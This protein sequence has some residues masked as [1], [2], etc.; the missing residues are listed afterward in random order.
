MIS[1]IIQARMGSTRLPGKVLKPLGGKPMLQVQIER[2]R[3]AHRLD[4]VVVATSSLPGDDAIA[5]FCTGFEVPCF[6]GSETDVLSRYHGC[7][8]ERGADVIVRLT[9]DCP[10]TD[11]DV[12]DAVVELRE[13]EDA[14]YACNTVPPD[15]GRWPDGSDVEVFT[16]AAL[17]RAHTEARE[18][19]EREHVTFYLWE[20]A[21]DRGFKTT[22]LGRDFDLSHLRFTV[23]Y[24]EDFEVV[25]FVFEELR[26]KRL[27]GHVDE[28]ATLIEANPDIKCKNEKYFFGIGWGKK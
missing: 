14:D 12:I 9:A 6:R 5:D 4:E 7:A 11:P 18:D 25:E 13:R 2:A 24:P 22:Q 27:F 17:E 19:R 10:L 3:L 20:H 15:T 16:R 1:A 23:D 28:V 26:R 21:A 8:R